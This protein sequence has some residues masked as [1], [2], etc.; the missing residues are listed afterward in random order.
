[1]PT[2]AECRV[3][4]RGIGDDGCLHLALEVGEESYR[5]DIPVEALKLF[6]EPLAAFSIAAEQPYVVDRAW[7]EYAYDALEAEGLLT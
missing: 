5:S 6:S 1:M 4:L 7:A 3:V 2:G